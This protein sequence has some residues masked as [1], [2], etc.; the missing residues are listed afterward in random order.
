MRIFKRKAIAYFDAKT[1]KLVGLEI[2]DKRE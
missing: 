2:K 1:K